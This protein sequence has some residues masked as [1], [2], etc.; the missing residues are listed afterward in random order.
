MAKAPYKA[1]R[2]VRSGQFVAGKP[3]L[4][5]TKDGVRILKPNGRPTHFTQKELRDAVASVVAKRAG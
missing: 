2:S 1:G 3:V 5:T 4:G